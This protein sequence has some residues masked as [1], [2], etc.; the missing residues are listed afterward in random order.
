MSIQEL[1]NKYNDP[2]TG[3]FKNNAPLQAITAARLREFVSDLGNSLLEVTTVLPFTNRAEWVTGLAFPTTAIG[4][5]TATIV[6]SQPGYFGLVQLATNVAAGGVHI[7][8]AG[9]MLFEKPYL[10]KTRF[11]IPALSTVG[12]SFYYRYGLLA[13]P[14]IRNQVDGMYIEYS[15]DVN[16][17]KFT[18]NVYKAGVLVQTL[19]T[20]LAVINTAFE[21]SILIKPG[22]G[23]VFYINGVEVAFVPAVSLPVVPLLYA[24][25][26]RKYNGA[27]SRSVF[28]DSDIFV[29]NVAV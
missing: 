27:A 16:A 17:D 28:V 5:G 7:L 6:D 3:L 15:H 18:V 8:T 19:T 14:T 25:G 2:L 26:I 12:D 13:D 22:N 11:Y 20:V 4:G 9:K 21:L 24:N 1:I 29:Y 23:A 10:M